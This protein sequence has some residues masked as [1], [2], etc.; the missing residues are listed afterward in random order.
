MTLRYKN[1]VAITLA[2][3]IT[4][5]TTTLSLTPGDG[6]QLPVIASGTA[7]TFLLTLTDKNGNKEI[8]SICRRDSSSDT[9]YVG[10]GTAHQSDGNV[11]GRAQESTTALAITYTDDH[12][13]ELCATA[14]PLE[15]AVKYSDAGELTA[16]TAEINTVVHECTSTAAELSTIHSSSV[17]QADLIK[18]HAVTVAASAINTYCTT[19]TVLNTRTITAGTGLSGG[20]NLSADRTLAHAAHT[21]DVT[22]ATALTIGAAK[23]AQSMLKTSQG[24]VNTALYNAVLTLPGGEYGFHP[25]LRVSEGLGSWTAGNFTNTSYTT[26]IGLGVSGGTV[27]AQQ[28]YVTSS[29]EV[30][31][32]FILRDKATG[33]VLSMWQAPDHP[34][35]GNGGKPLLMPHPFLDFDTGTQEIIVV[36]PDQEEVNRI[37]SRCTVPGEDKP[38]RDFL[39]V[40]MDEYEINEKSSPIWTETNVTVGL[41]TG[42]DWKRVTEGAKVAPIQ[43]RIPKADML[44]LKTIRRKA[45]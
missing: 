9:L 32:I 39:D 2:S 7:D 34:C 20:G 42:H 30:F 13:I 23:V 12:T 44:T 28:R 16:T 24:S 4:E 6:A 3:N 11:L 8:I 15:A 43:K 14:A 26:V 10:T 37:V 18:L 40:I 27:Y 38:D 17:S 33:K 5:T 29:G 36:N 45:G 22:G 1:N 41:P 25:Q 35:M 19:S 31:W 21:G